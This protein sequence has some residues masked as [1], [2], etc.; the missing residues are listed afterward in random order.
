MMIAILDPSLDNKRIGGKISPETVALIITLQMCRRFIH[1]FRDFR[2][3]LF[4][5]LE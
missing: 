1:I 2:G 3:A 5:N 4:W